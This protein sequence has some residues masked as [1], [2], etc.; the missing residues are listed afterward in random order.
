MGDWKLQ[1]IFDINSSYTVSSSLLKT[2]V[3][4]GG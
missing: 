1:L 4:I 2:R 3:I